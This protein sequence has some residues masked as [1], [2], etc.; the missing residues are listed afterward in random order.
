MRNAIKN[1]KDRQQLELFANYLWTPA[2]QTVVDDRDA[3]MSRDRRCVESW[4]HQRRLNQKT[5]LGVCHGPAASPP[6]PAS[7]SSRP[8]DH[9]CSLSTADAFSSPIPAS[10]AVA[11]MAHTLRLP[12]DA[13]DAIIEHASD[14]RP[15]LRVWTLVSPSLGSRLSVFIY[16]MSI[17]VTMPKHIPLEIVYLVIEDARDDVQQLRTWTEF[18][19]A[20]ESRATEMMTVSH[21]C[22]EVRGLSGDERSWRSNPHIYPRLPSDSTLIPSSDT[23]S[24][25]PPIFR[26]LT[27]SSGGIVTLSPLRRGHNRIFT[28]PAFLNAKFDGTTRSRP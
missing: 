12:Q 8:H 19:F 2:I 18:A 6:S 22:A 17:P 14:D 5:P 25:P 28:N 24:I 26:S 4:R 23:S 3:D 20:E 21:R 1:R 7:S 11:A 16:A 10:R 9:P 15:Q 27:S 13:L